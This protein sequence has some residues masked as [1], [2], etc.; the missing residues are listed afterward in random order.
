VTSRPFS[1]VAADANVLMSAALGGAARRVFVKVPWLRVVTTDWN[2]SE[3]VEHLPEVALKRDLSV[4]GT[5]KA[6]ER[7]PVTI[8]S[9]AQYAAAMPRALRLMAERDRDDADLLALALTLSVPIWSNDPHLAGLPVTVYPTAI[10]LKVL[11]L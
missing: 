11:G 10:L 4:R 1:S 9:T 7:L 8:Y 6:F 3:A 2:V 5:L